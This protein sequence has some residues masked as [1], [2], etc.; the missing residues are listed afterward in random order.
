MTYRPITFNW[1]PTIAKHGDSFCV[2]HDSPHGPYYQ[3]L[4]IGNANVYSSIIACMD[5]DGNISNV[6]VTSA[7]IQWPVVQQT[8]SDARDPQRAYGPDLDR[9]ASYYGLTRKW[10]PNANRV[11]TDAELIKRIEDALDPP[12]LI[13][14]RYDAASDHEAHRQAFKTLVCECGME[15]HGFASHSKWCAKYEE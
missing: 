12:D 5:D 6:D 14:I 10:N 11:E 3:T 1:G 8:P 4:R 2:R 9:T 15:K 7:D 13:G